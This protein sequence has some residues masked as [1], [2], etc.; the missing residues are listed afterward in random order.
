MASLRTKNSLTILLLLTGGCVVSITG[1]VAPPLAHAQQLTVVKRERLG[2]MPREDAR[3]QGLTVSPDGHH[4]AFAAFTGNGWMVVRDGK[5]GRE[6]RAVGRVLFS[7]NSDHLV[8][9]A[10]KAG[11]DVV[12][13]DGMEGTP[14]DID[15]P[16]ITISPDGTNVAF[17]ASRGNK[18]FV[19]VQNAQQTNK[20]KE[21]DD[22][23][24]NSLRFSPDGKR[25]A[26]IAAFTDRVGNRKN[27]KFVVVDGI[28][29]KPY[30]AIFPTRPAFSA[31]SRRVV[32]AASQN[33]D[34]RNGHIVV[35]GTEKEVFDEVAPEGPIFSPDGQRW[36]YATKR[37]GRWHVAISDGTKTDF[38]DPYDDVGHLGF[39][40]A[41]GHLRYSAAS[42]KDCCLVIDGK[43]QQKL[44]GRILTCASSP[45]RAHFAAV[46]ASDLRS[47]SVAID[48]KFI[49]Q[50]ETPVALTFSPDSQR[51][52][53]SAV[54][55][56]KKLWIVYENQRAVSGCEFSRLSLA[57]FSPD[58]RRLAYLG[59]RGEQTVLVVDGLEWQ[60]DGTTLVGGPVFED[61]NTVCVYTRRDRTE[62]CHA[63]YLQ[64]QGPPAA[65]KPPSPPANPVTNIAPKRKVLTNSIGMTFAQVPAGEFHR[66]EQARSIDGKPL[67]YG[68]CMD[69]ADAK[70]SSPQRMSL[71]N[72]S[73]GLVQAGA[74]RESGEIAVVRWKLDLKASL[75]TSAD[76]STLAELESCQRSGTSYEFEIRGDRIVVHSTGDD[77]I[78]DYAEFNGYKQN[79]ADRSRFE[80][81]NGKTLVY[82]DENTAHLK[83]PKSKGRLVLS[84]SQRIVPA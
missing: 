39:N 61:A 83:D 40:S 31:D 75:A 67:L 80:L 76:G 50:Y 34:G 74:N 17:R 32:Y 10:Q 36:A 26:Y 2:S 73:A 33:P 44:L 14:H 1:G 23:L 70:E 21:Y 53:F 55:R 7:A 58:S 62:E 71:T 66:P 12:V 81:D 22:V 68:L 84:K 45:D 54:L 28:E 82:A 77:G 46:F 27:G 37:A 29:G 6:Y 9:V 64:I 11:N 4:L 41:S 18:F 20:H 48:N 25:L 24:P 13:L 52:A 5:E 38:G 47:Y 49:G 63:T 8:Y 30:E 79:A 16:S 43:E 19:V 51:L 35:E 3:I 57:I 60:E 15:T 72:N 69:V 65:N 59:L 78:P 56:G 42:G